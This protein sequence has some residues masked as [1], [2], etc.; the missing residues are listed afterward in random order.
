MLRLFT[1]GFCGALLIGAAD[2][3]STRGAT[4]TG[5]LDE[6][7]GPQYVLRGLNEL[8]LIAELEP[9]GFPVQG[10]AKYLGRK[11][12]VKGRLDDTGEPAVMRVRSIEQLPGPCAPPPEADASEAPRAPDK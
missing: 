2:A 6:K 8:K 4:L 5:C 9:E 3:P 1:I 12:R 11:V 10:F 7:A